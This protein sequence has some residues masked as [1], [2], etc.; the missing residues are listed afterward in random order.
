AEI[1]DVA[2]AVYQRADSTMTSEETAKAVD[3]VN[4]IETMTQI[5]EAAEEEFIA[6]PSIF[7]K[8]DFDDDNF[9]NQELAISSLGT[10]DSVI[11]VDS[12]V[13]LTKTGRMAEILSN[14]RP[15]YPIFALTDNQLTCNKLSLAYGVYPMVI[16]FDSKN[17]EKTVQEALSAVKSFK[18]YKAK[19]CLL[20]TYYTVDGKEYPLITVRDVK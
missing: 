9:I 5:I 4:T 19:K 16:K 13:V 10:L 2:N 12:I 3:P 14:E 11:G 7:D 6:D 17:Y 18:P 15:E 8:K 1:S 20:I